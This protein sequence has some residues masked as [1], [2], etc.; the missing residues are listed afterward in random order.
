MPTRGRNGPQRPRSG[1]YERVKFMVSFPPPRVPPVPSTAGKK[2]N[3]HIAQR[4]PVFGL[5]RWIGHGRRSSRGGF[6][7][8]WT[9]RIGVD[10]SYMRP[11]NMNISTPHTCTHAHNRLGTAYTRTLG[12][13]SIYYRR[14]ERCIR[15]IW[16]GGGERRDPRRAV[17]Q[18]HLCSGR[19][20]VRDIRVCDPFGSPGRLLGTRMDGNRATLRTHSF[21]RVGAEDAGGR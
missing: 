8:H 19:F 17:A 21:I 10:V 14:H 6:G 12:L 11:W 18:D 16:L 1:R 20:L 15:L 13:S 2:R 7:L 5:G 4:R 3:R 9:F